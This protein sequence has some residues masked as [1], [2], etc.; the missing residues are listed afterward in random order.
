MTPDSPNELQLD[1][2]REVTNVGCGFAANAL[3][4]LIGGRKVEIAV[5]RVTSTSLADLPSMMGGP[6]AK[7]V[8]ALLGLDGELTGKLLLVLPENDAQLLASVMLNSPCEGPLDGIQKSALGEAANIVASA[9]LSAIGKLTGFK[10]LPT[11]PRLTQDDASAVID[12]ALS[13]ED[14]ETGLVVVL[15]AKFHAATAPAL[16]G[17]FLVVPDRPSLQKLLKKL[18]L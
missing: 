12:E 15:E 2:L 7:V 16:G 5:P 10:L 3:S 17:Q 18:G 4:Q 11:P 1:A 14:S 8:A 13:D 9:C 6:D